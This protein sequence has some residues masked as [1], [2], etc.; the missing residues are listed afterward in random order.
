M[1]IM[2]GG[3][4]DK[5]IHVMKL[6]AAIFTTLG[7]IAPGLP[8][9]A[10]APRDGASD[11]YVWQEEI[12]Q[13]A[14]QLLRREPMEPE[15]VLEEAA[16]GMRI[17]YASQ[18][19]D[20]QWI[21]VSGDV[22]IPKGDAPEGGWPVLAWSHGTVGVADICAPSFSGRS[23]RD[24]AY[25]NK[26][27]AEGY[28]I[29]STDYEGLG[30]PG[31]HTYLHCESEARGNIDAVRAAAQLDASLSPNWIVIGQS[32]GGQGALCTGAY[33]AERAPESGFL[34][35]LATAP[36]VNWKDRFAV[37]TAEDPVP[38][39]GMSLFLARGFE[40]YEPSF[41]TQEAF[42]DAALALMPHTD[43]K[44]VGDVIG[45]GMQA[46]LKTGEALK[47]VPFGAIPGASAGAAKMEVPTTGWA[48]PVYIAQGT[49]D[50]LI[51]FEDVANYAATLCGKDID[52]MLDVYEGAAHS[53]PM[54]QGFDAF[55]AWVNARF[56]GED[57]PNNC[58]APTE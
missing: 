25:L 22:L 40:V 24:V 32:Q 17:L 35:T 31:G 19:W 23:P 51:R 2:A 47:H 13:T 28:A 46:K 9:W 15:L 14:G 43:N 55:L 26:W 58:A 21:A 4:W 29:V 57:A 10:D 44:C 6:F 30:T 34:G 3:G 18:G 42:T 37:G 54:N 33:V 16:S 7:L 48:A 53:G 38:F 39:I 5:G 50:P 27:L 20:D 52:V 41:S 49:A 11:F 56:A 36:A 45:L 1:V 12:P 8:A